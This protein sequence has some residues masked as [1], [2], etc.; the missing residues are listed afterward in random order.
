M[1]CVCLLHFAAQLHFDKKIQ[2]LPPASKVFPVPTVTGAPWAVCVW[3]AWRII[4]FSVVL[5][6]GLIFGDCLVFWERALTI[7][8]L[9]SFT[10]NLKSVQR[11]TRLL[12]HT[13]QNL[14]LGLLWLMTAGSS[15]EATTPTLVF[16][17]RVQR[18]QAWSQCM[19][20][21][22]RTVKPT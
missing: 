14:V 16:S 18:F 22:V 9:C 7:T 19:R 13:D 8:A 3:L 20:W 21:G 15:A 11:A 1:I 2:Q 6:S 5:T 10:N 17:W 12:F 4:R